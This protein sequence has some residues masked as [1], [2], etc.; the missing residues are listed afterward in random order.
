MGQSLTKFLAGI[1]GPIA[2][3]DALR[4]QD[5]KELATDCA[6]GLK[7]AVITQVGGKAYGKL[8]NS[9]I[10]WL[11]AFYVTFRKTLNED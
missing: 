6:T 3:A 9:L 1:A 7:K 11:D 8:R 10:P 4:A 2:V 5:P